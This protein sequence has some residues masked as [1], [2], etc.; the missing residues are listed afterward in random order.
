MCIMVHSVMQLCQQS[1]PQPFWLQTKYLNFLSNQVRQSCL[2]KAHLEAMLPKVSKSTHWEKMMFS[3]NKKW[4]HQFS[5]NF[6]WKQN[7]CHSNCTMSVI[8]YVVRCILLVPCLKCTVLI[9]LK[10]DILYFVICLPSE[11]LM[12]SPNERQCFK[13][14][15]TILLLF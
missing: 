6:I 2:L 5:I 11:P 8:L 3:Y 15:N 12:T 1:W 9:F 10:S 7:S 14:E 4:E 13:N